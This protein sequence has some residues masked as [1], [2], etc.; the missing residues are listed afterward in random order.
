MA[1]LIDRSQVLQRLCAACSNMGSFGCMSCT[2]LR[3]VKEIP[4]IESEPVRHGRCPHCG[5][6]M[7]GGA[8][9]D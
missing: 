1:D 9:N 7:D 8:E 3:I 4:K 6:R 5:A 2:I